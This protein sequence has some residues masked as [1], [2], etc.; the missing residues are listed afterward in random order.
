VP[1]YPIKVDGVFAHGSDYI[2]QDPSGKQARLEVN[3][4]VKDKSGAVINYKYTGILN[5]TPEVGAILSGSTDAKTTEF[6]DA[7][8]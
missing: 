5:V 2:R 7:C 4:I 6:G 8:K 1:G 3:S